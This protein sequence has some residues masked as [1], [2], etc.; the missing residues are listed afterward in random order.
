M[1]HDSY[2]A[3]CLKRFLDDRVQYSLGSS[4]LGPCEDSE[5]RADDNNQP[6]RP[7]A[8][9]GLWTRSSCHRFRPPRVCI[10][11]PNA[12]LKLWNQRT[13]IELGR[14]VT[15]RR[16]LGDDAVIFIKAPFSCLAL[17]ALAASCSDL[18]RTSSC[19]LPSISSIQLPRLTPVL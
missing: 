19:H 2:A 13:D 7:S 3:D 11:W 10:Y 16:R 12:A 15:E 5:Q 1:A 14:A 9:V 6:Q 17:S 4:R 8:C 18:T